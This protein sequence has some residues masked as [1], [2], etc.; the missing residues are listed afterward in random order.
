MSLC[1]YQ[2]HPNMRDR[3][4]EMARLGGS[5]KYAGEWES[6]RAEGRGGGSL[7]EAQGGLM[8]DY[9]TD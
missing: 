5:P 9:L 7:T 6:Y 3:S 1:S 4:G 8:T 2:P